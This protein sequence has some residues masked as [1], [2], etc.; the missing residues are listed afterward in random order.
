M[1]FN[2]LHDNTWDLLRLVSLGIRAHS[3]DSEFVTP[4]VSSGRRLSHSNLGHVALAVSYCACAL[5][6]QLWTCYGAYGRG[7]CACAL[8]IER[9]GAA[10]ATTFFDILRLSFHRH[11]L[12]SLVGAS[13]APQ[14]LG[15]CYGCFL[16]VGVHMRCDDCRIC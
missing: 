8:C 14:Q 2:R 7:A 11:V 6:I 16:F 5:C 13:L 12:V 4:A 10:C 9:G 3:V 1:P 15:T